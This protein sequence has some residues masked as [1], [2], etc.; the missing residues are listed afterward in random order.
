MNNEQL[1]KN[2]GRGF[3]LLTLL[4]ITC[5][6]LF[7]SCN[8][9]FE[10]QQA[11]GSAPD[12]SVVAEGYGRV[13]ISFAEFKGRTV[14]PSAVFEDIVYTFTPKDGDPEVIEPQTDGSFI[15]EA[16]VEWT[17][18]VEAYIGD[19][20][21]AW[22]SSDSF[23]L[24][25]GGATAIE[26]TLSAEEATGSGI[27]EYCIEYPDT[28]EVVTLTLENLTNPTS[29][30]DLDPTAETGKVSET[31]EDVP[32][33]F[34]VLTVILEDG[35]KQ[36]GLTEVVHIYDK[37]TTEF[38]YIF[39]DDEFFIPKVVDIATVEGITLPAA[40]VIPVE[41]TI[42]ETAQYT[43]TAIWNTTDS[44]FAF[45]TE[46]TATITLTPKP[47]YTLQGVPADF[48]D[49]TGAD[50]GTENN[51]AD[52]GVITAV[53]RAYEYVIT[54][55]TTFTATRGGQTVVG[56]AGQ[57]IQIV[58][59]A[60]H[61]ETSSNPVFIQ[62]GNGTDPLDIGTASIKFD[63]T[64]DTWGHITLLGGITSANTSA[65]QG[66]IATA[67][68]VSITSAANIAN[69]YANANGR[70]IYHNS[71]GA[72]TI[73]GGTVSA[74]LGVAVYN[75]S[76][77]LITV[78]GTAV[79]TSSNTTR[80]TIY[81]A[82]SGSGT[83][84]RLTI[85]GGTVSN[86]AS[87]ADAKAVN[88]AS[89]G[90]VNIS[91]GTVSADTGVA[92]YANAGSG[93]ITVSETAIVKSANVTY[94]SGTIF[95]AAFGTATRLTITGGTV[96]NTASDENARA[97][98]NSDSG[99]VTISGGTVSA[100]SGRAVH[101]NSTGLITVSGTAVVTSSNATSG[102]IYLASSDS[103]TATRLA[104]TGGTVSNTANNAGGR[105]VYNASTG[106]VAISGG[107]VSA[108][109][110]GA[111]D[112]YSTGLITVSGTAMVTSSSATGGTI[113]LSSSGSGTA[114][115]LTI[116]GGTVSNTA[117]NADARAVYNSST[118]A[119][120]ISGGTVSANTG[121]AVYNSSTGLITV[122]G[123]AVV[124]SS[125]DTSTICL[126]SSGSDTAARLTITGGTVS[127]TASNA[128]ATAVVNRSTGA[129]TISGGTVSATT[130]RAVLNSST[131]AVTISG[132]TVSADM[133]F[134]VQ[135]NNNTGQIN[136]LGNPAIT[137]PIYQYN[138]TGSVSVSG[139]PTFDPQ[140]GRV[141]TLD[142]HATY[143]TAGRVAV[144][145][146]AGKLDNF[147]VSNSS[148]KL[149]ESGSDLVIAANP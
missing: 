47:G 48:F 120:T 5:Y 72:I 92:V 45:S 108:G 33:G 95:F 128:D 118:G 122:S 62:F 112:N 93:P 78:S 127:N 136:L 11:D 37:L 22:G 8:N 18:E 84:A 39:D 43:G 26:I 83:A 14:Y 35:G 46:Y 81:L 80:A 111:V 15:L 38:S 130:G 24:V 123:T 23:T 9:P 75:N 110:G 25:S 125:S 16:E 66:T 139:T 101:N 105:A 148:W 141:Y 85:T 113:T 6:L 27:F 88:N 73:S 138:N 91:G 17:L 34:Y 28:A 114:A 61:T 49:V 99:A 89:T 144:K 60:I 41:A 124:T 50:A 145:G 119:V 7:V 79:V 94:N 82:S 10:S 74:I 115:R 142:F 3:I 30:V 65:T 106:A 20:L 146:G 58:I 87:N 68:A 98:Y 149:E 4:S 21:V 107:T 71:I 134:A 51:A 121:F 70:A 133:N 76:T 96:S 103:G 135:N 140:A 2:K 102:T 117:S 1:T 126:A 64:S 29:D 57:S 97:V 143:Y 32:A 104:I 44:T 116:T 40:G 137:G 132:G 31:V 67:G 69:T 109:T 52:S 36:A 90:A 147:V 100:T 13:I 55:S 53:F 86:T 19:D 56:S 12:S 77:G 129:V 54:G 63:D 42:T 131:G 59:D